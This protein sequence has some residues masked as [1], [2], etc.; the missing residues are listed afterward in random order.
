MEKLQVYKTNLGLFLKSSYHLS[1]TSKVKINGE[2][3]SEL[4]SSINND[5]MFLKDVHEIKSFERLKS[6]NSELVGYVLKIAA[7]A[8]EEIPL[9]LSLEDVQQKYNSDED[10]FVWGYFKEIKD[11]YKEER[12]KTEDTWE[13]AEFE[14]EI[15]REFIIENYEE[16]IKTTVTNATI[17]TKVPYGRSNVLANLV[18]Y[19]DFEKILTPEVLLH[20]RPCALSALQVYQLVRQYVKENINPKVARITSDYDFCFTVKKVIKVKPYVVKKEV[21]KQNGRSYSTPKYN[22]SIVTEKL[23]EVFNIAPKVYQSYNVADQWNADNLKD[24]AEQVRVYLEEL[25]EN[26][27]SPLEECSCCKGT[28]VVLY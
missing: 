14:V 8:N 24:M 13:S 18:Q 5:F 27:N 26:I 1:S 2:L 4:V 10:E 12:V 16:P 6:G 7:V 19:S 21:K 3:I 23:E 17:V 15:L 25:M 28:G 22:T 20:E 9:K 11:L